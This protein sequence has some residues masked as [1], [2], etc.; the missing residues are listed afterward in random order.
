M[1]PDLTAEQ[2][3]KLLAMSVPSIWR[4]IKGGELRAYK[5]RKMVRI[6]ADEID[7]FRNDNIMD[8]R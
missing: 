8:K 1:R 2:A 5:V 7:R 3:S 6:T 4:L